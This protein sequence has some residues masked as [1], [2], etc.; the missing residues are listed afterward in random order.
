[1]QMRNLIAGIVLHCA[2]LFTSAALAQAP[3]PPQDMARAP[4]PQSPP[5]WTWEDATPPS[6][7]ARYACRNA[8]TATG[9]LRLCVEGRRSG[10]LLLVLSEMQGGDSVDLSTISLYTYHHLALA[11]LSDRRFS[12]FWPVI[13]TVGGADG[14]QLRSNALRAQLRDARIPPANP[15][16]FDSVISAAQRR[17]LAEAAVWAHWGERARAM[18]IIDALLPQPDQRGRFTDGQQY[19]WLAVELRRAT[20]LTTLNDVPA[21]EAILRRL[22]ADDRIWPGYRIN[23][24]VNLA[25]LLVEMGQP[26]EA[27]QLINAAERRFLGTDANATVS[28]SNRQFAWIRA[29]A[30]LQLGQAQQAQTSLLGRQTTPDV[31]LN[32]WVPASQETIAARSERCM[33]DIAPTLQRMTRSAMLPVPLPSAEWAY[34]IYDNPHVRIQA[35]TQM[36]RR[37]AMLPGNA[38]ENFVPLPAEWAWLANDRGRYSDETV[39]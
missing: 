20:L 10:E 29:C 9:V 3:L 37:E 36:V 26:R 22:S 31:P 32:S 1:M 12:Y 28:G 27:L 23:A 18:A 34:L 16:T 38:G 7:N 24:D 17:S 21:A 8:R 13:R 19:D 11:M 2:L 15:T 4:S 33:H 25:A 5:A 6:P 39:Q 30:Q 35:W 14:R